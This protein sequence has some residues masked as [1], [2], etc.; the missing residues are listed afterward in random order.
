MAESQRMVSDKLGAKN[1]SVSQPNV[2]THRLVKS[3]EVVAT[4]SVELDV[5][6]ARK[7]NS[8]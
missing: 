8:E 7:W 5:I 6:R 4:V 1:L 2:A 3:G